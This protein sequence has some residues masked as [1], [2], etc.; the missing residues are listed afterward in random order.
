MTR[1]LFQRDFT[2]ARA[3]ILAV[4]I[5]AAAFVGD[6]PGATN[7]VAMETDRPARILPAVIHLFG[8]DCDTDD[9]GVQL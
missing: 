6:V 9:Q 5:A 7:D 3:G 1:N 4:L 8:A 2:L